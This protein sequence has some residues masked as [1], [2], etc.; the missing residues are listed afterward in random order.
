MLNQ[1]SGKTIINYLPYNDEKNDWVH[2]QFI[3]MYCA[4]SIP[5]K[6]NIFILYIVNILGKYNLY[7]E[8]IWI[9]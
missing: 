8:Y 9:K 2:I 5:I 3:Q 4:G 6:I 7:R 1:V